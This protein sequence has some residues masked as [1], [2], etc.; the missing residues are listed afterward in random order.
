MPTESILDVKLK[1][2]ECTL[3]T[4]VDLAEPDIDG[5]GSLGCPR[6]LQV[7]KKKV[8]MEE[9][10]PKELKLIANIQW[11]DPECDPNAAIIQ[12]QEMLQYLLDKDI[13]NRR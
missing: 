5:E 6:C 2:P 9:F 4:T 8:V 3:I 10:V 1:C 13:N 12:I 11:E 7:E